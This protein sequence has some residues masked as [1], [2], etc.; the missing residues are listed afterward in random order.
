MNIFFHPEAE[1]ELLSLDR[2]LLDEALKKIQLLNENPY[3]GK[4]L[5]NKANT[6]LA[7]CRKIYFDHKK[8]RIVYRLIENSVYVEAIDIL[9][10]G[11]REKMEVYKKAAKRL[12][13]R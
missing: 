6:V 3:L 2:G 13:N 4:L 7:G 10:L 8:R 5:G 1:K 12:F 11:D 9:A